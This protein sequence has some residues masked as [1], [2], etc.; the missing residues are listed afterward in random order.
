[1]INSVLDHCTTVEEFYSSIRSQ[2]EEAHGEYY[3][4]MHEA[5][6]KIAE[7]CKS[8]KELG[9]H[10]GGTLANA[11]LHPQLKYVE[12]IDIS[13]EK[14]N[15]YLK[16][17]A[18]T[19][20]KENKKVLKMREV[21]ST[22]IEALG[23]ATD[24]LMIDSYHKAYHMEKEL[25]RHG[26]YVKKYIVAHDTHKPDDQLFHCMKNWADT[27]DFEVIERNTNNVGYTIMRRIEI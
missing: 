26:R 17:L 22:G 18:E 2:Q 11:L 5:I 15:K 25:N 16:P 19:Y 13:L 7:D 14:Y 9:V 3:C 6:N 21:D 24:I 23:Y 20:A 27:N 10:Q 12:G 4:A 8:Y 1:M